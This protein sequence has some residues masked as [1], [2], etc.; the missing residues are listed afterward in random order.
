MEDRMHKQTI[1]GR[2]TQVGYVGVDSTNEQGK[3]PSPLED[4]AVAINEEVK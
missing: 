4:L 3:G 2:N 1:K